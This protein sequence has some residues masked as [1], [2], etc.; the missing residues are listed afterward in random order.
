M[1]GIAACACLLAKNIAA[2]HT[3]EAERRLLETA[4]NEGFID[5]ISGYVSPSADG[6]EANVHAAV[7]TLLRETVANAL[8]TLASGEKLS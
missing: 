8:A 5:G 1:T 2:M 4:A 7:I 3:A 6:M